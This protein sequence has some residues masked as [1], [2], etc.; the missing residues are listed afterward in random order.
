VPDTIID[1]VNV[2]DKAN[3]DDIDTKNY[4]PTL[5]LRFETMY[6]TLQF[7]TVY[8]LKSITT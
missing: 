7:Y 4:S 3:I 8:G 2:T 1:I 5:I 6:I